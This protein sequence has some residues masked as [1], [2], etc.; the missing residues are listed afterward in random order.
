MLC[1]ANLAAGSLCKINN[2]IAIER[3]CNAVPGLVK[4]PPGFE[5]ARLPQRRDVSHACQVSVLVVARLGVNESSD[6][7]LYATARCAAA[8][9]LPSWQRP[10]CLLSC[11]PPHSAAAPVQA[12]QD[13]PF[14]RICYSTATREDP[15]LSPCRCQSTIAHVHGRWDMAA[16]ELLQKQLQRVRRHMGGHC[17]AGASAAACAS[18]PASARASAVACAPA[19][20]CTHAGAST[21]ARTSASASAPG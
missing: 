13:A 18:A 5:P 4:T 6:C 1:L 8:E 19:G 16:C 9:T 12:E 3:C 11:P 17:P 10:A 15:L 14:W 20:A 21:L 2:C 7:T